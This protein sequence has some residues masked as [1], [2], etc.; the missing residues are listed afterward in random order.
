MTGITITPCPKGNVRRSRSPQPTFGAPAC[1]IIW[2]PASTRWKSW[3]KILW[4]ER[5]PKKRRISYG[6][7]TGRGGSHDQRFYGENVYRKSDVYHT[8]AGQ[9]LET[10]SAII[11]WGTRLSNEHIIHPVAGRM[12]R[13]I[14]FNDL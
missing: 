6:S 1:P 12:V 8:V 2:T 7:R 13:S 14:G 9:D 4:G 3:P 5:I 10:G 11:L